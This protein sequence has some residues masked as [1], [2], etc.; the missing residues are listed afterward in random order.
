LHEVGD[1]GLCWCFLAADERPGKVDRTGGDPGWRPAGYSASIER[2][3]DN[4]LSRRGDSVIDIEFRAEA[5]EK[6]GRIGDFSIEIKSVGETPIGT[7][8]LSA[9][10]VGDGSDLAEIIRS[11]FESSGRVERAREHSLSRPITL[12]V[13]SE[14]AIADRFR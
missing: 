9:I 8:D 2:D 14:G 5:S 6:L 10:R 7:S 11:I 3:L 4:P 1:V 13:L 12:E